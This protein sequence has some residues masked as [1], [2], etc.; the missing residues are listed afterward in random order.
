M[1]I[2][3]SVPFFSQYSDIQSHLWQYRGCGIIALK[4]LLEYWH[5]QKPELQSPSIEELLKKSFDIG[6]YIE[7]IG[8]SH[9]GLVEIAKRYGYGGYNKD[10]AHI[11]AEDAW[12][13]FLEDLERFP[14]MVSA[15]KHFD[16]EI[17]GGHIIVVTGKDEERLYVNDP[18]EGNEERGKQIIDLKKFL[19]GWKQRY[20]V[21]YPLAY[22]S[23]ITSGNETK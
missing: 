20:I 2:R 11:P 15:Y 18:L 13:E 17:K 16:P 21:V 6:A 22:D 19:A 12:Q 8:W 23:I 14:V 1:P 5:T 4:M 9:S 7:N 10:L 3:Y